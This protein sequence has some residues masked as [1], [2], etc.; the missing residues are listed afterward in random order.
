MH[1]LNCHLEVG[2]SLHCSLFYWCTCYGRLF[3]LLELMF[4]LVTWNPWPHTT[5]PPAPLPG[6]P[7][8]FT[9][10]WRFSTQVPSLSVLLIHS[11]QAAV[12][13]GCHP[14]FG[15][16]SGRRKMGKRRKKGTKGKALRDWVYHCTT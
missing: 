2:I 12:S 14:F 6:S 4:S 16:T 7:L 15:D 13:V 3:P 5:L 1:N 8:N 10:C 11:S 9:R